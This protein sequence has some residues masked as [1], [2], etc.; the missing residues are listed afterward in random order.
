MNPVASLRARLPRKPQRPAPR[1]DG[2]PVRQRGASLDGYL[3]AAQ[4]D[5]SG[6][7]RSPEATRMIFAALRAP[8][9]ALEPE[10]EPRRPL[11]TPL[12]PEVQPPPFPADMAD[13]LAA[14]TYPEPGAPPEQWAAWAR[15]MSA[16]TGTTSTAISEAAPAPELLPALPDWRVAEKMTANLFPGGIVR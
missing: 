12:P 3:P 9:P 6:F 15:E 5:G 13:R 2:L 10:P 1:H 8:E 7:D 4:H 14:I 11:F 16:A